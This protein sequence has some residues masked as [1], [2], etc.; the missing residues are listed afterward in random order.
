MAEQKKILM[1]DN[2][3]FYNAKHLYNY[4][5]RY[6]SSVHKVTYLQ[7]Q[8]ATGKKHKSIDKFFKVNYEYVTVKEKL[9]I[10]RYQAICEGYEEIIAFENKTVDDFIIKYLSMKNINY[11]FLYRNP[12]KEALLAF[13]VNSLRTLLEKYNKDLKELYLQKILDQSIM[14]NGYYHYVLKPTSI[15]QNIF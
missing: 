10:R 5:T 7:V 9:N 2:K 12:K 8:D 15:K 3:M 4:L 14:I 1:F 11:L 13:K 6:Y